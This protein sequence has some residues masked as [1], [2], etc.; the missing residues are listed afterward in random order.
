[1]SDAVLVEKLAVAEKTVSEQAKRLAAIDRY[2]GM[3]LSLRFI[4]YSIIRH[5][6]LKSCSSTLYFKIVALK[7]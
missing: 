4:I 5:P 3:I 1:M 6:L 2:F 7:T